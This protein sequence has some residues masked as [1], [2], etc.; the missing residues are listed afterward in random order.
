MATKSPN[1]PACFPPTIIYRFRAL[2]HMI[3]TAQTPRRSSLRMTPEIRRAAVRHQKAGERLQR[4]KRL[5]GGAQKAEVQSEAVETGGPAP[6]HSVHVVHGDGRIP[7]DPRPVTTLELDRLFRAED[8]DW[9][10]LLQIVEQREILDQ[11]PMRRRVPARIGDEDVK[12]RN[13][14]RLVY[15]GA[16]RLLGLGRRL[17]DDAFLQ[18]GRLPRNRRWWWLLLRRG[19]RDG[20]IPGVSAPR[21][22][23]RA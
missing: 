22:L 1:L 9:I 17:G 7:A 15:L 6:V 4:Q 18:H 13:T 19:R 2:I 3:S 11:N 8:I 12:T 20:G 5:L 10:V 16:R 23:G 14:G 21:F